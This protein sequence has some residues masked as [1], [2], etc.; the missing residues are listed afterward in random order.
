[1][2]SKLCTCDANSMKYIREFYGVPARRGAEIEY[3]PN[4]SSAPRRGRITSANGAY[5]RIRFYGES[6][7]HPI[8]FHPTW[9]LM[10]LG[11]EHAAE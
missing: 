1:M 8:S 3:Q 5:L 4:I 9:A 6:R 7:T 2:V 11:K 10:Y